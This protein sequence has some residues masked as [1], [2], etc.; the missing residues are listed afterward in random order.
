MKILSSRT[1]VEKKPARTLGCTMRRYSLKIIGSSTEMDSEVVVFNKY[2]V[3]GMLYSEH[4]SVPFF[5]S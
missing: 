4:C 1:D 3:R 5:K 2:K